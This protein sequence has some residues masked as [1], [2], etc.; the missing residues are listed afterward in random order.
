MK[1]EPTASGSFSSSCSTHDPCLQEVGRHRDSA[2]MRK[3]LQIQDRIGRQHVVAPPLRWTRFA[4]SDRA[5]KI[6]LSFETQ[7]FHPLV[8]DVPIL[9]AAHA[10]FAIR[11]LSRPRL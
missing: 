7:E 3:P 9:H 8:D 2:L 1:R 6:D 11:K 4:A 10:S 5:S